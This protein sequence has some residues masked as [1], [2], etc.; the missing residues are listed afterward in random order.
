MTD[1]GRTIRA[2]RRS[3]WFFGRRKAKAL[4]PTQQNRFELLMPLIGINTS[5]KAPANISDL[6]K[7]TPDQVIL[8]IGFGGGEHLVHQAS[9]FARNAYLGVEPFVNSMAKALQKIDSTSL[10]NVRLY[11]KDASE[12]LD[13][14]PNASLDRIDL[15]YPDPWPKQKHW[16]RRFVSPQNLDR[17][18]RVIRPGGHFHFASDIESYVNWTLQKF[19]HHEHFHWLADSSDG[20]E[21]PFSN[22]IRTRYEAKALREGRTP[23]YLSFRRN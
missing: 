17:F 23:C 3:E 22:W 11:E 4:S 9:T 15:L 19:H 1:S 14:L 6:F 16:K 18:A 21:Q 12:L 2:R 20:W 13:W 8:E 7:H 10:T 5:T